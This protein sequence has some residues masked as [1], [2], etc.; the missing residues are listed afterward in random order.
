MRLHDDFLGPISKTGINTELPWAVSD[1][2]GT[3]I[4]C[5]AV[6]GTA[7]ELGV[8]QAYT[9]NN[10]NSGGNVAISSVRF[11]GGMPVG[12][13][14]ACKVRAGAAPAS[15][16]ITV[17]SG[18]ISVLTTEVST[19]ANLSFIGV[20]AIQIGANVNWFGVVKDGSTGANESTVDLGY[21]YDS[22]WRSFG[23]R[24][25][26]TGIQFFEI[27]ASKI[28]RYGYLTTDIG[29]EVT[30]NIPTADLRPVAVGIHNGPTGS[31]HEVEIDYFTA[32]GTIAR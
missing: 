26:S 17:W 32:A 30:T 3:G 25:T 7:S 1:F 9:G 16:D 4:D 6:Y 2:S 8:L 19:A 13:A 11:A 29:A 14:V 15:L 18:L 5:T 21:V 28:S 10:A 12:L 27:D 22:T 20:R 23:W 24:R 31:Q